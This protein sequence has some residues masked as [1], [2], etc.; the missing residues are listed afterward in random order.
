[1]RLADVGVPLRLPPQ[2]TT[3]GLPIAL[4][5]VGISLEGLV[6]LYAGL[7]DQGVVQPL[8]F[9]RDLQDMS[10]QA[11][12]QRLISSSLVSPSLVSPTL[13][14]PTLVSPAAAY[15]LTRILND[16]PPQP[17]WLANTNRRGVSQIAYKTVT[18][19]GY[20][21]AWAIGFN[22]RYTI[23]VWV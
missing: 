6:T 17:N 10:L 16:T 21:D 15:Y 3:P 2:A 5:G 9:R 4:G 12:A 23:G 20:R 7:A 8:V 13:V 11:A 14:S 22:A 19:Y 18:S 1:Q